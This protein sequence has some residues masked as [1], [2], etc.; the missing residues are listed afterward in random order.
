VKTDSPDPADFAITLRNDW[1]DMPQPTDF[2]GFFLC[3]PRYANGRPNRCAKCQESPKDQMPSC[4]KIRRI[5]RPC[6]NIDGCAT[7][8]TITLKRP[9]FK[10]KKGFANI[11]LGL[12]YCSMGSCWPRSRDT[13]PLV[14]LS[15]I[16]YFWKQMYTFK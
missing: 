7:L 5:R 12:N 8:W 10:Q 6:F 2:G 13:V 1:A 3:R 15:C 16:M 14:I 11:S 4:S 9:I